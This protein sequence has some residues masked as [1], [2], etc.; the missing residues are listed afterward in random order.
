MVIDTKTHM[1]LLLKA[2]LTANVR[3]REGT[4]ELTDRIESQVTAVAIV[5]WAS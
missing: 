3:L 4:L 1:A 2:L 5:V